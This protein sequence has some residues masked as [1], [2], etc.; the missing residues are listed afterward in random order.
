MT[1]LERLDWPAGRSLISTLEQVCHGLQMS[2]LSV[3]ERHYSIQQDD[4]VAAANLQVAATE[5]RRAD[6]GSESLLW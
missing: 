3:R 1:W 6:P 5:I 2:F 4:I